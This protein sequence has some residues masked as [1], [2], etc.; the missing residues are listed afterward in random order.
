MTFA[1]YVIILMAVLCCHIRRPEQ[2]TGNKAESISL[3]AIPDAKRLCL[4]APKPQAVDFASRAEEAEDGV[5][6]EWPTALRDR[7]LQT[8]VSNPVRAKKKGSL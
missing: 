1:M 4:Q 6:L 3:S 5:M 8:S 2:A 7:W